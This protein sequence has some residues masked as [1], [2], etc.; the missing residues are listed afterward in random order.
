MSLP[1]LVQ[2][3]HFAGRVRRSLH[4]A[5]GL[6]PT[7]MPVFS[8]YDRHDKE[9]VNYKDGDLGESKVEGKSNRRG[10]I[11]QFLRRASSVVRPQRSS[12]SR[13]NNFDDIS[14]ASSMPTRWQRLRQVASFR[15][16]RSGY[17]IDGA[18]HL[19]EASIGPIPG[20]G[21]APPI[22]P[23]NSG[24]AARA[25]AA[26]QNGHLGFLERRMQ[27]LDLEDS[28]ADRESGVGIV[29][30]VPNHHHQVESINRVDFITALP[31]ELAIQILSHLD[32]KGLAT[33]A[34][35]S[36][37]WNKTSN[38]SHVWREAFCREKSH[39]YATSGPIVSGAGL[40]L[41]PVQPDKPWKEIYRV[42]HALEAN[43]RGGK[44]KPVYLN[45]HLDSIYC[46]QFDEL[47]LSLNHSGGLIY[48]H[49]PTS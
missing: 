31:I 35:V 3:D 8:D 46:V 14:E 6:E 30:T 40:G 22:I 49:V 28:Q 1:M 15:H 47:V 38:T 21:N 37:S 32:H 25:T 18:S 33:A 20:S 34:L 19:R 27:Q 41:P 9:N 12:P 16:S 5:S 13:T 23:H 4:L 43:W 48:S 17:D 36:R 26:A 11:R 42:R 44:A 29:V 39:T 24:A 7:S 45:G 10:S 2:D